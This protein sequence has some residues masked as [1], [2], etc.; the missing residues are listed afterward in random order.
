[1]EMIIRYDTILVMIVV[2]V[3]LGGAKSTEPFFVV[4]KD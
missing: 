4:S 2:G 1:M 3:N